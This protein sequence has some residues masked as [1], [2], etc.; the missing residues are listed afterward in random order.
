MSGQLPSG[1]VRSSEV[2]VARLRSHGRAMFWPSLALIAIAGVAGYL[3]GRFPDNW[4]NLA[5]LGGAVLLIVVLWFF[6]LVAWLARRYTI[7][8]RRTIVRSGVIV[9]VRQELLHAR[10]F[11]VTVRQGGL[12]GLFGS[13][14]VEINSGPD[15]RVV[16][17]DVPKADLVQAALHDLIESNAVSA[18]QHPPDPDETTIWGTR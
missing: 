11:D 3:F 17:R 8:T 18:Q 7:T 15:R 9:R 5:V 4:E 14:D 6:P 2:V 12:Q 16:L 13:G 10:A 1:E